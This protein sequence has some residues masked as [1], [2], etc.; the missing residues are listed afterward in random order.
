MTLKVGCASLSRPT[1]PHLPQTGLIIGVG[2]IASMVCLSQFEVIDWQFFIN[3]P[4]KV[5]HFNPRSEQ[6]LY[7]DF[8]RNNV[9]N[10]LSKGQYLP[11]FNIVTQ[12]YH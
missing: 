11:S 12:V 9:F 1:G 3:F 6:F 4:L 2:R 7:L 5:N 8:V 10:H